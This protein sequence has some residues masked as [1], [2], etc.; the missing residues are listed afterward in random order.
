MV[1][2][3]VYRGKSIDELNELSPKELIKFMPSKARRSIKRGMLKKN[4]KFNKRIDNAYK[5]VKEGKPQPKI[6]THLRSFIILPKMVGL[7]VGVHSGKEFYEVLIKP[8]MIGH[9]LGE[10]SMTRRPVKHST[11]GIGA[12]KS[13]KAVK[14]K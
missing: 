5:L 3:A 1:K 9:M 11:P 7:K 12:S 2:P 10:Y 6:K 13:S 8:E 4:P 14:A